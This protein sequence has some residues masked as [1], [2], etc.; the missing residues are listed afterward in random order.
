MSDSPPTQGESRPARRIGNGSAMSETANQLPRETP[1]ELALQELS[2]IPFRRIVEQSLAG[3]YVVQDEVVEYVN[4][5][6]AAMIGYSQDEVIGRPLRDVVAPETFEDVADRMRRRTRGE[7]ASMRYTTKLLHRDGRQVD[8]EVHGSRIDY[9]GRPAIIGALIDITVRMEQDREIRR[10]REQ[11]RQLAAYI[12][13][14]REEQRAKFA[15]ELHDVVGGMLTSIKMDATRIRRRAESPDLAEICDTLIELTKE[16][17]DTVRK[18]SEDLRPSVLDHLGLAAAISR[19]LDQFAA[20]HGITAS[21]DAGR[22]EVRLPQAQTIAAYRIFQEALT[23]VARH[24]NATHVGVELAAGD[25]R[26]TLTVA[27]NGRGIETAAVKGR[28]IGL[29][30]MTERAR[31]LGGTLDIA[32]REPNGTVL[33]LSLPLG[34]GL[35]DP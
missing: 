12:N 6:L 15:R 28:S 18:M 4:A 20:R 11:L 34:G 26:F 24:A 19:H 31:E 1:D 10:S 7:V 29:F 3:I 14:V 25:G 22:D 8:V 21:F 33:R 5:T 35:S 17:I 16:T 23:N 27:D 32:R 9:R 13:G 30:S 2:G